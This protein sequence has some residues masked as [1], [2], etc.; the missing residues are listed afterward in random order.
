MRFKDFLKES[1]S[2]LSDA[3]VN[4]ILVHTNYSYMQTPEKVRELMWMDN[5][6]I[7]FKLNAL[8]ISGLHQ[9]KQ[10]LP[11]DIRFGECQFFRLRDSKI[12]NFDILP[13]SIQKLS[14]ELTVDGPKSFKGIEKVLDKCQQIGITDR[15][16]NGFSYLL[17]V[18]G[19]TNVY[20]ED[21]MDGN[22][23]LEILDLL[24]IISKHLGKGGNAVFD[25]QE[26]LMDAGLEKYL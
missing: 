12:S 1:T 17:S 7:Q 24:K 11:K 20:I 19:L 21:L 9:D 23:R 8:S 22:K 13:N 10:P 3:Q 6:R 16:I 15:F 2:E 14:F 4:W 26:E 5:G 25:F 18:K